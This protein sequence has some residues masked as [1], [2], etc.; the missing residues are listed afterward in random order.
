MKAAIRDRSAF[1]FTCQHCD[2]KAYVDYGFL[3]HQM[4]D[5]IMI[6]YAQSEKAVREVYDLYARKCDNEIFKGF[7]DI[8][9]KYLNRTGETR[10]T[11]QREQY[12]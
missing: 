4:E 3:Y 5:Q 1:L 7:P 2:H 6:H 11:Y 8:Q 12:A 9:T 10:N